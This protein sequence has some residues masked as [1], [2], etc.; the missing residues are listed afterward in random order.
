MRGKNVFKRNIF[1]VQKLHKV[2][3][4]VSWSLLLCHF[5]INMDNNPRDP[6]SDWGSINTVVLLFVPPRLERRSSKGNRR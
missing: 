1:V 5:W 3:R 6:P 4:Q 2:S